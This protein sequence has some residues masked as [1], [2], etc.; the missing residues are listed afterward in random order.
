MLNKVDKI[1]EFLDKPEQE[2]ID[3]PKDVFVNGLKALG[4]EGEA[5][6]EIYKTYHGKFVQLDEIPI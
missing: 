3:M 1:M 4:V 5:A 2:L 6:E